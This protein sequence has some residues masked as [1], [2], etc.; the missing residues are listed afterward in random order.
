MRRPRR[1]D[2]VWHNTGENGDR[3]LV[4]EVD[5]IPIEC[6]SNSYLAV[7]AR[8]SGWNTHRIDNYTHA[9][10]SGYERGVYIISVLTPCVRVHWHNGTVEKTRPN[11]CRSRADMWYPMMYLKIEY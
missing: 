2:M 4:L 5:Y 11:P 10:F 9:D 6:G 8:R 3:G 7:M 1:G